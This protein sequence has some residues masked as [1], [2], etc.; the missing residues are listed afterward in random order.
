MLWNAGQKRTS[1][2]GR[3]RL[4][5]LFVA[6]RDAGM[7]VLV[8]SG[9]AKPKGAWNLPGYIRPE[10]RSENRSET[11][12]ISSGSDRDAMLAQLSAMFPDSGRRVQ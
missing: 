12:A 9:Q 6:A 2:E 8:K 3:E 10:N 11:P 1:R 5:E 4:A 7:D